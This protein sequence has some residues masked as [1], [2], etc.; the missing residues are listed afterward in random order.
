M[1]DLQILTPSKMSPLY[2]KYKKFVKKF[3]VEPMT[4]EEFNEDALSAFMF[5]HP[6]YGDTI[7][8]VGEMGEASQLNS[9]PITPE[10][11]VEILG[12]ELQ[13]EALNKTI[14]HEA[15]SA[16]DS[17]MVSNYANPYYETFAEAKERYA[18][19]NAQRRARK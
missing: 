19:R 14:G 8:I 6:A 4:R 15:S 7:F 18:L 3:G 9:P 10:S 5:Q 16:L 12:H 1:V 13:H 11:S 2:R 17:P